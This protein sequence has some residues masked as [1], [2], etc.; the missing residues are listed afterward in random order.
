VLDGERD[1]GGVLPPDVNPGSGTHR[2]PLSLA[3][4]GADFAQGPKRAISRRIT[5]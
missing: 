4:V 3:R 2:H 5:P 1:A